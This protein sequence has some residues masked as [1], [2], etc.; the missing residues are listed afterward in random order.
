MSFYQSHVSR[1]VPR[2]STRFLYLSF[3][4]TPLGA[5]PSPLF[6]DRGVPRIAEAPAVQVAEWYQCSRAVPLAL[7]D[8]VRPWPRAPT[9]KCVRFSLKCHQQKRER[10]EAT[11][12]TE[13]QFSNYFEKYWKNP[14]FFL[15]FINL[16]QKY[17]KN[18]FFLMF[19]NLIR[20]I[21]KIFMH[22]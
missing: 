3:L 16:I 7:E 15:M 1:N 9:P 10:L 4:L 22:Y 2:P 19:I 8:R 14:F 6:L 21:Y 12:D 11:T 17:W 13:K 18:P 20:A 5:P